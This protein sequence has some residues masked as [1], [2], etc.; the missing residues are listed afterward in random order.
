MPK[1]IQ[2]T[3]AFY[4]LRLRSR[5]AVSYRPVEDVDWE[6]RLADLDSMKW[7]EKAIDGIRYD[8]ILGKEYPILSVSEQFDPTFMQYIDRENERV[9]DYMDNYLAGERG[10]LAKSSAFAFFPEYALIGRISGSAGKSS[11]PLKKALD[12]YWSPGGEFEW[13]VQPVVTVD[14]IE[15][16][17]RELKE[18]S[19][20]T[21]GF[22]TRRY[23]DSTAQEGGKTGEF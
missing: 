20:F 13:D 2:R 14:S 5:E 16:F 9:T 11:E 10:D 8:A 1:T 22:T 12:H 3:V 23:L 19:S 4:W 21:A 6:S 15:R 18:L 7:Q 17:E